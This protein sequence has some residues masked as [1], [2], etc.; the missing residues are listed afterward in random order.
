MGSSLL[1]ISPIDTTNE[2]SSQLTRLIHRNPSK[3][4]FG[5]PLREVVVAGET[6]I[7]IEAAGRIIDH[8]I[9]EY[10]GHWSKNDIDFDENF[11]GSKD[12]L[13]PTAK[14]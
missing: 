5:W 3:D 13:A 11:M 2:N 6:Y 7:L 10:R 8:W 9:C 1:E 14:N 4:W 12:I